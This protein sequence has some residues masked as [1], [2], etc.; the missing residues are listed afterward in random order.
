M[1][2]DFFAI[3][4]E[5]ANSNRGSICALGWAHVNNGAIVDSGATLTQPP[6][7]VSWFDGWNTK[8]HGI[9]EKDVKDAPPLISAVRDLE[10]RIGSHIVVAHNAGFDISNINSAFK[11]EDDSP[12][13][14]TFT[15]SL[16]LAR[17]ILSLASYRLPLVAAELGVSL[18]NHHE[19]GADAV[20]AAE[21]TIELAKL[22][23]ANSLCELAE[24][25]RVSLGSLS[26]AGY[27]GSV[28]RH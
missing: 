18:D 8:I 25:V 26:N 20:A 11:Y 1:T 6:Q 9:T 17:R 21:I 27:K 2:I 4:V 15:C 7:K 13:N 5:T 12:P 19:A 14:W 22:C 24:A 3:D 16:V 23:G 28:A 10:K